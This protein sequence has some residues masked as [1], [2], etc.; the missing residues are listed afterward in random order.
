MREEEYGRGVLFL[1]GISVSQCLKEV[2]KANKYYT[3][4]N[5]GPKWSYKM[6]VQ[7]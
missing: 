5:L 2:I 1:L 7:K 4:L 3:L 6:A